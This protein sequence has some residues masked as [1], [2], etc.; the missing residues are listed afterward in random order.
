[1][2]SIRVFDVIEKGFEAGITVALGGWLVSV[3]ELGQKGK[4]LIRCDGFN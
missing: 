1:L 3:C 2:G 4:N